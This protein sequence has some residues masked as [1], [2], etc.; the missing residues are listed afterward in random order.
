MV[1]CL[2]NIEACHIVGGSSCGQRAPAA[3][4]DALLLAGHDVV[5]F[6]IQTPY[7]YR[8][9]EKEVLEREVHP[10]MSQHLGE[11]FMMTSTYRVRSFCVTPCLL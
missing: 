8:Q 10:G 7:H 2:F 5:V 11:A 3:F 9:Y 1:S 4:L 6:Y